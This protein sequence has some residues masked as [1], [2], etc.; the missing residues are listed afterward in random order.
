[1]PYI[2]KLDAFR[3]RASVINPTVRDYLGTL[4]VNLRLAAE[5]AEAL[6]DDADT[7]A[8]MGGT[9]ITADVL[10]LER[11]ALQ[12][13]IAYHDVRRAVDTGRAKARVAIDAAQAARRGR[14]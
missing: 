4:A 11:V 10:E 6:R 3:E 14:G 8:A 9:R 7:L 13:A 1:M 5:A 2:G 12:F